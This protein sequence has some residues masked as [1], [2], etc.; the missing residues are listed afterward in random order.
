MFAK[1]PESF[2]DSRIESAV[3]SHTWIMCKFWGGMFLEYLRAV[4]EHIYIDSL[5]FLDLNYH[6]KNFY[7]Q[8]RN[9]KGEKYSG[10]S[11]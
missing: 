3:N 2:L 6:L 10:G 7:Y 9:K 1:L 11:I 4:E 5:P 8:L